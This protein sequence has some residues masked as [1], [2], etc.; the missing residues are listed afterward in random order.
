MSIAIK[1]DVR[2]NVDGKWG[3]YGAKK[4]YTEPLAFDELIDFIETENRVGVHELLDAEKYRPYADMDMKLENPLPLE[5]FEQLKFEMIQ[6][7]KDTMER[8]FAPIG[9]I[10]KCWR[11]KTWLPLQSAM[12]G[13]N[14]PYFVSLQHRPSC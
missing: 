5:E 8:L 6:K 3:Y 1:T 14:A 10:G 13:K 4:H 12:V 7:G 9:A 11:K 2:S